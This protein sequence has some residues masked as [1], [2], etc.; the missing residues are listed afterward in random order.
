MA[1]FVYVLCAA[2]AIVCA[3]LLQ[4][5]YRRRRT[6][7][8]LWSAVGFAGLSVNNVMLV[9]DLLIVPEADLAVAR[10]VIGLVSLGCI[11]V[12]LIWTAGASRS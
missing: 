5:Q 12:G 8:L 10:S 3:V 1:E 6:A 4:R 9:L 2:T 7:L 11:L